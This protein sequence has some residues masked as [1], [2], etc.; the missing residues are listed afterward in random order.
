MKKTVWIITLTMLLSISCIIGNIFS[1]EEQTI[2]NEFTPTPT[3]AQAHQPITEDVEEVNKPEPIATPTDQPIQTPTPTATSKPAVITLKDVTMLSLTQ[4]WGVAGKGKL[5]DKVVLTRDG[6][7]TW[8]TV[9]NLSDSLLEQGA[10]TFTSVFLDSTNAWLTPIGENFVPTEVI[11]FH[12]T[13]GGQTWEESAPLPTYG[14]GDAYDVFL[15]ALNASEAWTLSQLTVMGTGVNYS[16]WL[17]HT[18]DGGQV[19]MDN[20]LIH[21]GI[22]GMDFATGNL[23]ALT[24]KI[25]GAY[26]DPPPP[27][28]YRTNDSGQTWEEI[29]LPPPPEDNLLKDPIWYCGTNAVN[30]HCAMTGH[31]LLQCKNQDNLQNIESYLYSTQDGA[32]SWQYVN[33]LT[34]AQVWMRDRLEGWAYGPNIYHT[35]DGGITWD[36]ISPWGGIDFDISFVDSNKGWLI[37]PS[38][39]EPILFV[40]DDGGNTWQEVEISVLP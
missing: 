5:G 20:A 36:M 6:G 8:Q 16:Q 7:Q 29:T 18:E 26:T 13:D 11:V 17:Y 21:H 10:T 38:Q 37:D 3:N 24:T 14:A 2:Q 35:T 30:L 39:S 32:L 15:S 40:T 34:A 4:G 1:K 25:T 27:I 22:T 12:T 31:L 9:F 23:G 28:I 33:T 19:W